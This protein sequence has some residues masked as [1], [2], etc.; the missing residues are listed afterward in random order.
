MA[1][2][3]ITKL[4]VNSTQ[5]PIHLMKQKR[6]YITQ[7]RNTAIVPYHFVS[8]FLYKTRSRL[9]ISGTETTARRLIT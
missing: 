8:S 3:K 9:T 4:R 5:I 2:L 6:S 1:L 7:I